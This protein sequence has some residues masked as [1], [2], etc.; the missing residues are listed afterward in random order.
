MGA[1][2]VTDQQQEGRVKTEAEV[3]PTNSESMQPTNTETYN[4]QIQVH[5]TNKYRDLEPTNTGACN[6]QIQRLATNKY[7][8][9]QPTNS[10]GLQSTT[11]LTETGNEH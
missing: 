6:Q 5:A 7:R 11:N 3:K 1:T 4:Q 10:R 2:A 9:L 8:A